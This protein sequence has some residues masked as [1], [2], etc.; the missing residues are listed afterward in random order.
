[1]K[2]TP[3]GYNPQHPLAKWLLHNGLFV[4]YEGSHPDELYKPDFIDYCFDK[5]R[6][7]SPVHHWLRE[8][9]E[10]T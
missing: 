2:K 9:T 6:E 4:S 10:R 1:Y 8:M 7:M 3:R 5:F